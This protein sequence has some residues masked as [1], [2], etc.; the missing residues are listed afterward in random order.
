MAACSPGLALARDD[1]DEPARIGLVEQ[2]LLDAP[3]LDVHDLAADGHDGR[4]ADAGEGVA[5]HA[6]DRRVEI[7]EAVDELC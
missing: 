6:A 7:V 3:P 2:P 4:V 1:V 5:G